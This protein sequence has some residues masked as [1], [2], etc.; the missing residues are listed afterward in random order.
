MQLPQSHSIVS[1]PLHIRLSIET[2]TKVS[3]TIIIAFCWAMAFVM[4]FT[5]MGWRLDGAKCTFAK[6]HPLHTMVFGLV[7]KILPYVVVI[8][9]YGF[10]FVSIRKVSGLNHFK[11]F[12][13]LKRDFIKYSQPIL[14][15]ER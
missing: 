14:G 4:G 1:R 3:S 12:N 6:I 8:S 15:F 10:I 13:V 2:K 9:C 5:V 11:T 7:G